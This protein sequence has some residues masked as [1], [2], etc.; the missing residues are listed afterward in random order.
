MEIIFT[1]KEKKKKFLPAPKSF[2]FGEDKAFYI[3]LVLLLSAI[4]ILDKDTPPPAKMQFLR[5]SHCIASEE[6]KYCYSG[7]LDP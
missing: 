5:I 6:I 7:S 2:C 1:V 4:L 3:F